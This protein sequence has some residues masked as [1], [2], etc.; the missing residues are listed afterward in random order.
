MQER[1]ALCFC[2]RRLFQVPLHI[3]QRRRYS[4]SPFCGPDA[5]KMD[6]RVFTRRSHVGILIEV[7][8][9]MKQ[10]MRVPAFRAPGRQ[11]VLERV[12]ASRRHLRVPFEIEHRIEQRM[13]VRTLRRTHGQVVR[14]RLAARGSDVRVLREIEGAR[15]TADWATSSSGLLAPDNAGAGC[16]LLLLSP[17]VP[18]TTAHRTTG[19]VLAHA[20]LRPRR[21]EN[22]RAGFRPTHGGADRHRDKT[23]C[24]TTDS[25]PALRGARREENG[26]AGFRPPLA[27]RDSD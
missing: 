12:P 25:D 4:R 11:I 1:V 16:A 5:K 17:P 19:Q 27:R 22:G 23:T 20:L 2:G 24:R 26:R 15:R 13:R 14:E 7:E 6:E 8:R 3:E 21:E 10:G 18:G 9:G